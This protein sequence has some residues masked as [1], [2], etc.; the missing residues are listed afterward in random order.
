MHFLHQRKV[1][2]FSLSLPKASFSYAPC[3]ARAG[4]CAFCT[5][6]RFPFL[7]FPYLYAYRAPVEICVYSAA[8]NPEGAQISTGGP[9]RNCTRHSSLQAR[10]GRCA[11]SAGN[12]ESAQISTGG[13]IQSCTRR[14]ILLARTGVCAFC[15]NARFPFLGFPYLK[16]LSICTLLLCNHC[17]EQQGTLKM[18]KFPLV[19]LYGAT[20][21]AVVSS[22]VQEGALSAPAKGFH[23]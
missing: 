1:S 17:T 6:A 9:I 22:P 2:I 21:D 20:I 7:G 19:A 10:A 23:F 4:W 5:N 14:S 16:L 11:F 18:R 8:G 3:L 13:H 15:T 12:P